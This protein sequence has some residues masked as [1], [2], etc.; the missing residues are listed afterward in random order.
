ME[1][2]AHAHTALPSHVKLLR[3]VSV[4]RQGVRPL[5]T[6][7]R[8]SDGSLHEPRGTQICQRLSLPRRAERHPLNRAPN[9][10]RLSHTFF[11]KIFARRRGIVKTR[12]WLVG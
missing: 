12:D 8:R 10:A 4:S 1:R 2:G 9:R 3:R 6:G 5:F 11:H 7:C